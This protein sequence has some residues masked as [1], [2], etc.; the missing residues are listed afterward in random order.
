M[1][2]S[3]VRTAEQGQEVLAKA[4]K[5]FPKARKIAVENVTN[6]GTLYSTFETYNNAMA[7]ARAYKWD[8]PTINAIKFVLNHK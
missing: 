2:T 3:N 7:D 5:K 1:I 6:W 8:T 4:F